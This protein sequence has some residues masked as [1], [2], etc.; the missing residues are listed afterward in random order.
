MVWQGDEGRR[1]QAELIE[2]LEADMMQAAAELDFERAARI[3]D[4]LASLRGGGGRGPAAGSRGRGKG[5]R[6]GGG[7]GGRI[8]RPKQA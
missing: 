4:E 3:R 2:Q 1:L 7:G 8:Q 5:R 6:A